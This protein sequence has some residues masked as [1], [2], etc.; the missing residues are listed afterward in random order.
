MKNLT[1]LLKQH[2]GGNKQ[3][4]HHIEHLQENFEYVISSINWC[5]THPGELLPADDSHH[6]P[7]MQE[8]H[9][10]PVESLLQSLARLSDARPD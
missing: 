10:T 7:P 6:Q 5:N 8:A 9:C 4:E 2:A 1:S 3:V